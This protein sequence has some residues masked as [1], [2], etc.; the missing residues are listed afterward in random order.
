M[1]ISTATEENAKPGAPPPEKVSRWQ[2]L[3]FSLIVLACFAI[4]LWLRLRDLGLPFDRDGYD[5]GVYWQTLRAM[6]T[7]HPLYQDTFYSQPPFFILSLFPTYLLSGQTLWAARLGVVLISLFGLLGAALL[8]GALRGRPGALAALFL[9]AV[10]PLYLAASQTV[11]AEAPSVAFSLLSVGLA[12]LWWDHPNGRRGICL[13]VLCGITMALGLLSKLLVVSTLIPVGLLLLAHLWRL[14]RNRS[15]H[16]TH[17][18]ATIT[19]LVAGILALLLTT[20]II[21]VPFLG[22]SQ[23]M[24]QG[25][26]TF[27]T[28]ADPLFK[29]TQ[30]KNIDLILQPLL[31]LLGCAALYGT[32]VALV[33]R[34]WRVLAL[35][36]WLLATLYILW[37]QIPLFPHHL[38]VLVPPLIA[39]AVLGL[40]PI[41]LKP[42]RLLTATN[43]ATA[44]ASLLL[45]ATAYTSFQASRHYLYDYRTRSNAAGGY[46]R[47]IQDLRQVTQPNQLVITDAQFIAGLAERST[48]ASL[49]DT[50]QVR[51]NTRYVTSEQLIREA[52][53]PQVKAVLFYTGR[54]KNGKLADFHTWLAQ[55]YRRLHTYGDGKEL[56]IK[57]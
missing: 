4:A 7:G 6:G 16:S 17:P 34:D 3:L 30:G 15:T 55:H 2:F 48:P 19:S 33:K 21:L 46:T 47:V 49:V 26:V 37:R 8:G 12:Y 32:L 43:I 14:S 10:D 38:V 23:Q 52:A 1:V 57:V 31:S 40:Q 54:L 27:H 45:L 20:V 29:A 39:L 22:A 36:A 56:W 5:E 13:A 18:P 9:L 50:S 35:L 25:V 28:D 24:W 11:Q 41:S 53:Q 42:R 51:I 44:L